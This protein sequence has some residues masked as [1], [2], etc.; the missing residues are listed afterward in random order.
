MPGPLLFDQERGSKDCLSPDIRHD[1]G[2]II[3]DVV[4]G[5]MIVNSS[6]LQVHRYSC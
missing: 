2:A 6:A 4:V 3:K 1:P 5:G